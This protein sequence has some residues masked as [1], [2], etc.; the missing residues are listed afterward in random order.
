MKS[1]KVKIAFSICFAVSPHRSCVT[2]SAKSDTILFLPPELHGVPRNCTAPPRTTRRPPELHGVSASN[3]RHFE[4]CRIPKQSWEKGT[5]TSLKLELGAHSPYHSPS[6]VQTG[7]EVFSI[8][9][10]KLFF[11]STT[12]AGKVSSTNERLSQLIPL[13]LELSVSMD[14]IHSSTSQ[15]PFLYQSF[16]LFCFLNLQVVCLLTAC[17]KRQFFVVPK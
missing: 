3:G 16:L 11:C 6:I 7:R 4:P 14:S 1:K 13:H 9:N 17:P 12:P 15:F 5:E 10:R 2:G 8:A